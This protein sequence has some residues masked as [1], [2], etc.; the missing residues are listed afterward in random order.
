[1]CIEHVWRQCLWTMHLNY[2]S[3][4]M[5]LTGIRLRHAAMWGL[6]SATGASDQGDPEA[7]HVPS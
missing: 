1:M 7:I 4:V 2:T 6:H 5:C 3:C